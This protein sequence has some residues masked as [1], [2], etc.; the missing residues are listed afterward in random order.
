MGY[1]VVGV[2][3]EGEPVFCFVKDFREEDEI[4]AVF[5]VGGDFDTSEFDSAALNKFGFWC[6][7]GSYFLSNR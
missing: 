4:G 2:G 1:F 7:Y 5:F 3:K 6:Y